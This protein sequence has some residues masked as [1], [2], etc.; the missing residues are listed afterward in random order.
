M[1]HNDLV[2][3]HLHWE[4]GFCRI[5]HAEGVIT[6]PLPLP[7]AG[8]GPNPDLSFQSRDPFMWPKTPVV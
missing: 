3:P 6:F 2:T 8:V 5:T 7:L 4:R 1:T